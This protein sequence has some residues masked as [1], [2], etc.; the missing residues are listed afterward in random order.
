V[1]DV[2]G[3]RPTKLTPLEIRERG[4]SKNAFLSSRLCIWGPSV[5]DIL[6]GNFAV[7]SPVDVEGKTEA[8]L[9]ERFER[10][11]KKRLGG[12]I[13]FVAKKRVLWDLDDAGAEEPVPDVTDE[14]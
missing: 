5:P 9:E 3:S 11:A 8:S 14:T 12:S 7:R 13:C 2:E 6:K 10:E 1:Q 4:A